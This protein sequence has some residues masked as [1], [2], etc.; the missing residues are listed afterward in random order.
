MSVWPIFDGCSNTDGASTYYTTGFEDFTLYMPRKRVV[1]MARLR[2]TVAWVAQW[3][4]LQW[5]LENSNKYEI[6]YSWSLRDA[7][8]HMIL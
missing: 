5:I 7:S 3:M 1:A 4:D 8:S 2:L 6:D